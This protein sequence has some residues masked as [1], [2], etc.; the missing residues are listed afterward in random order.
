MPPETNRDRL[1]FLHSSM[2]GS[3]S[4]EGREIGHYVVH[5]TRGQDQIV[6]IIYGHDVIDWWAKPEQSLQLNSV[7]A[8]TGTNAASQ[9]AKQSIQLFKQTWKNP[10]PQLE[11]RD[12]KFVSSMTPAAPFLIAI[13]A[14]P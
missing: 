2:F 12:I 8:W 1:H 3:S 9:Q 10:H 5:Y 11:V 7:V 4:L 6:P 14:E 13:T